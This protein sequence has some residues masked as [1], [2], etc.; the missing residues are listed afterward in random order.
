[1]T[2][3]ELEHAIRAACEVAKDTELYIFGSQAILGPFP[4]VPEDLRQSM[5]VD[6]A[7]KNRPE[8]ADAIDGSLGELSL[9]HKSHG[10]YVH[11]LSIETAVLAEGWQLR[12]IS[13]RNENTR[14]F[15]GLCLSGDDL[16]AS[17]VAAF[18]D[19]DKE[20]VRLLLS[21]GLVRSTPL[22]ALILV[23]PMTDEVERKRRLA[24]VRATMD[25]LEGTR[26]ARG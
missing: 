10:F 1:M 13:V 14:G 6:V 18:R 21:H 20:F 8:A 2:R 5:E 22:I 3:A 16:A 26:T 4:D 19:K 7:P 15:T 24:W 17:K 23:L 11:G 12:L 25:E 9:F